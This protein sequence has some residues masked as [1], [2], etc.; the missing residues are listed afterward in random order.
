MFALLFID[1]AVRIH[2]HVP[3][4]PAVYAPLLV[5]LSA[6]LV[7][8]GRATDRATAFYVG[9][10]LLLGSLTIHVAGPEVVRALG[11]QPDSWA[12]QVKVALKEGTEL[13]GWV[14]LV[15]AV[16]QVAR[17]RAYERVSQARLVRWPASPKS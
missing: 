1:E 11:W 7:S 6:S 4:W 12:Y 5:G 13:A 2:E 16:V 3:A 8:I 15:P 9:L 17:G 10:A 14:I